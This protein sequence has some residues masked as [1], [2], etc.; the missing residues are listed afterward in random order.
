MSRYMPD[1][2]FNGA[3]GRL[4]RGEVPEAPP[5]LRQ[6]AQAPAGDRCRAE[7]QACPS[8][9]ACARHGACQREAW[10]TR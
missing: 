4:L 1:R 6:R 5:E 10:W 7:G 3:I 9:A 2:L 8:S